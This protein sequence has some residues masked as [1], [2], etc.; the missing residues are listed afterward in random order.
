MGFYNSTHILEGDYNVLDFT[1]NGF[2][3]KQLEWSIKS[4][5]ITKAD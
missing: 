3:G 5:N 2:K 1:R 4:N